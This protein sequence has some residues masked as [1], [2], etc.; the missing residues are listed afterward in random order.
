MN[1]ETSYCSLLFSH[2]YI[3]TDGSVRP[4]CRFRFFNEQT[5]QQTEWKKHLSPKI[6]KFDDL[7]DII[8]T[9]D[10]HR[11]LQE[12]VLAGKK[13]KGCVSCYIEE[14]N[15]GSSMRTEENARWG[16]NF[17]RD[18]IT[19]KSI[20]ITFGNYCN[21]A[22]RICCGDLSTSWHD[23]EKILKSKYD[24]LSHKRNNADR[25]WK[26]TDFSTVEMIKIT[27][28]EPLLHPDFTRFLDMMIESGR[29]DEI[30]L[31]IFTNSSTIPKKHLIDRLSQFKDIKLYLSIDGVGKVHEYIRHKAVWDTTEKTYEKWLETELLYPN[32]RICFSPTISLFNIMYIEE[33]IDWWLEKRIEIHGEIKNHSIT[34]NIMNYPRH[35]S[36]HDFHKA[37]ERA[38][39]LEE[40]KKSNSFPDKINDLLNAIIINLREVNDKKINTAAR[41]EFVEYTKDLDKIRNQRI[42]ESLPKLYEL[43]RHPFLTVSGRLDK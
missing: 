34:H 32:I 21:L 11:T 37:H 14:K 19:L 16:R 28:G 5:N 2:L 31:L 20:E 18:N 27:G 42:E 8:S 43:Y 29:S 35:M 10:Q 17:D 1:R 7:T 30:E 6:E 26:S 38:N 24:F 39:E 12:T 40:Y 23:D 33:L 41:K 13:L 36:I 25:D 3:T 9:T 22:C 15:T 4:C